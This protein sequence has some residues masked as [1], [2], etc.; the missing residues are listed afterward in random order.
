[1][2]ADALR[3]EVFRGRGGKGT[4]SPSLS[5]SPTGVVHLNPALRE[6][7][8][9]PDAVEILVD[10]AERLLAFR[11]ATPDLPTAFS[12]TRGVVQARRAIR[13]LLGDLPRATTRFEARRFGDPFP[14]GVDLR[15]PGVV[16]SRPRKPKP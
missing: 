13:F 4:G 14:L 3:W 2:T 12:V 10:E 6:A 1:V 8:G 16:V 9:C 5:I 15:K 7:L 11:P